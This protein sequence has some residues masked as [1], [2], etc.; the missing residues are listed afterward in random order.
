MKRI[1]IVALFFSS[2]SAYATAPS[3]EGH[4][5]QYCNASSKKEEFFTGNKVSMHENYFADQNCEK[6][7][8][9]IENSGSFEIDDEFLVPDQSIRNID[10]TYEVVR[11]TLHSDRFVLFYSEREMCGIKD[12]KKGETRD[13][14]GLRC[15]FFQV[16]RPVQVP[17]QGDMRYGIYKIEG[18]RL[19]FG[20]LMPGYDG[21]SPM[22][23][24]YLLDPRYF[25]KLIE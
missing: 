17:M 6:L 1:L 14:T 24:P 4:W 19:Y 5:Q 3:L 9:V 25:V 8:A 15:E 20:R 7:E 2:F 10:F 18:T 11:I 22:R 23:R 16:G 21:S 12:W 13:I